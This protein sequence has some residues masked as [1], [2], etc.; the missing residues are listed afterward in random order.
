GI[1]LALARGITRRPA[2]GEPRTVG[3]FWVDLIRGIV[4]VLLPICLVYAL[5]LISQGVIQNFLPYQQVTTL[6][7]GKQV[8]AMGPV[9]SQEAIKML[10]PNGG[11]FFNANSAPP[12]ENPS[13]LTNMVQMLSIFAIPAALTYAYGRMAR[14]QRQGWAIFAA[15][16]ILW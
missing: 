1:A 13:P 9:A 3:N 11:G 8:L 15:M 7:G 6:E 5:F 10:G 16:S 14:S 4:Y 2:P 12:F